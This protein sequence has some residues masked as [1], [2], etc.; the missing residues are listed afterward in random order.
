MRISMVEDA[1]EII[2]IRGPPNEILT[3]T[4]GLGVPNMRD[5]Q[6]PGNNSDT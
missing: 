1:R 5:T 2:A 3:H 4:L 6:H